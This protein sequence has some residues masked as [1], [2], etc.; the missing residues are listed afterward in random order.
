MVELWIK[1]NFLEINKKIVNYDDY[2]G[3]Q[4]AYS[5]ENQVTKKMEMVP[6]NLT[7]TILRPSCLIHITYA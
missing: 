6:S 5:W 4:E 2:L 7:P 3:F 1:E